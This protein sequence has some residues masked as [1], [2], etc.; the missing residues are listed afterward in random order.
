[1][2]FLRTSR[3]D[4]YNRDAPVLLMV[5]AIEGVDFGAKA[6][7]MVSGEVYT[8][9]HDND[10]WQALLSRLKTDAAGQAL[11]RNTAG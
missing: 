1:M 2:D 11:D 10:A 3:K 4:E 7:R 5:S 6:V 8:L 9:D